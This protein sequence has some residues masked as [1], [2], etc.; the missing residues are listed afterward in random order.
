MRIPVGSVLAGHPYAR[1]ILARLNAA[2]HQAVLVG[3][4]VRDAVLAEARGEA[5]VAQDVDI[6]TSAAPAEVRRLFADRKVLTVG[7]SF[8]VVVVVGPDGRQYEVA[9]FRTEDGYA[10]GRRP[11]RVR[12]GSLAEDVRRRDFT[13]NGLAADA[14]G[15]VLDLVK[16]IPDLKAGLIRAIGDPHQRFAEDFLRML[17]AVRLA[18]QLGFAIEPQTA[19]AIRAHAPR[20]TGIS[21]ERIRDE[22]LRTLATPRAARG[23]ALLEEL[24]LLRHVLP[25]IAALRGVPQPPEYHP[26]GDVLVHTVAAVGAADGVWDDPVLKLAVLFHDVGKPAAL[27]RSGGE[28]MGGHC[29]IG[30]RI[31]EEALTRL[32]L[33]RREVDRVAYLVREHMRVARLPEMGIGKQ[34][35]LLGE[36]EDERAP[37]ADLPRRFPLFADLLRLVICDAEAS[38]HRADAWRPLLSR[39]VGLLVHLRHIHGIRRAR[40]LITGDDLVALGARPGP[41]LGQVLSAVHER[42]LAGEIT[43]RDEALALAARLLEGQ[44]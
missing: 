3:G 25:E 2:G 35:R 4:A 14:D 11:D 33:P 43:T 22:L 7:E 6:A 17:R 19:A 5:F 18:C 21:W 23:V 32:R 37:L 41:R 8:G 30:A 27:E 34:V 36:G 10:D 13:V 38:A 39:S 12:W 1:E 44:R 20:I 28:N 16:G 40:E 9:T 15:E 24:G 31:A 26:E 42:I 29:G